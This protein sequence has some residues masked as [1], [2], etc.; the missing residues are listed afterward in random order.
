M[1]SENIHIPCC[2][3]EELQ[4]QPRSHEVPVMKV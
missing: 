3:F 4:P 1:W 2:V